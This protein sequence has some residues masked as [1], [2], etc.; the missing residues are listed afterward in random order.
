M[1][2]YYKSKSVMSPNPFLVL[3][4]IIAYRPVVIKEYHMLQLLKN[5]FIRLYNNKCPN[6]KK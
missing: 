3:S 6:L 2:E 1:F 5:N 4:F